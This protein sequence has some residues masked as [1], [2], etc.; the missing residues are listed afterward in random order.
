MA[1]Q[2]VRALA[3]LLALSLAAGARAGAALRLARGAPAAAAAPPRALRGGPAPRAAPRAMRLRGGSAA[4]GAVE[5]AI[6]SMRSQALDAGIQNEA[7]LEALK[8]M[9]LYAEN[10]VKN[11]AEVKF[12]RIKAANKAFAAKVAPVGGAV[13]VLTACGFAAVQEAAAEGAEPE[14]FYKLPADAPVAD[15]EAAV[16]NIKNALAFSERVTS[17]TLGAM[18]T[19]GVEEGVIEEVWRLSCTLEGHEADVRGVAVT[20][21]NKIVTGS[22]DDTLR[23]WTQRENNPN[24]VPTQ[25]EE[26]GCVFEETGECKHEYHVAC[27]ATA[28]PS[29]KF[30]N[31][32]AMAGTYDLTSSGA[33]KTPAVAKLWDAKDGSDKGELK[34]HTA[35]VSAIAA[36]PGKNGDL[37]TASWDKT[38][39]LWDRSTLAMKKELKGH[40]QAVWAVLPMPGEKLLTGS[41]DRSIKLW[42]THDGKCLGTLNGHGDCVRALA[43]LPDGN[44]VSAGNDCMLKIWSLDLSGNSLDTSC[45]F[46]LGTL[47][48]HDNFIYT[49]AVL[50]NG[51]IVSGGED[52][53]VRIWREGK[54][55]GC[56]RFPNTVWSV[57]VT[58][59]GDIAVGCA[60][61]KTRVFTQSEERM[62][63]ELE[64]KAYE[65]ELAKCTINAHT[66]GGLQLDKLPGPEAL[67]EPGKN[68]G[69][70]RV[71][72]RATRRLPTLGA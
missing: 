13:E 26:R 20:H 65:E 28:G 25:G 53:T 48:G 58:A 39:R 34:G 55:A 67:E 54:C 31:G 63:P 1:R 19:T 60:D 43:M 59:D 45:G 10:V 52:R 35:T 6:N 12:R 32:L 2:R 57:A 22:R 27:A 72:G 49:L 51:D 5:D 4:Q 7:V 11:P 23:L 66:M 8:L 9:L 37:V 17:E 61:G 24:K 50:P 47:A 62:A 68:D 56:V 33:V 64:L 38:I 46:C 40:S 69:Q 21:E 70:T 29:D 44:F 30:P 16:A 14:L 36:M 41:G 42:D 3:A 15:V 18:V 71:G